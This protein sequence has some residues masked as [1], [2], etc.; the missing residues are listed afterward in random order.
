M[1]YV[2]RVFLIDDDAIFNMVHVKVLEKALFADDCM[3]F[4]DAKEPLQI[5]ENIKDSSW[6]ELP[7]LIFL[8]ISMQGMDGWG[9]LDTLSKVSD[10]K[11]GKCNVV[12]L[13]SSINTEDIDKSKQYPVVLDFISKPLTQ[14]KLQDLKTK[15][16]SFQSVNSS[17]A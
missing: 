3:V 5:I 1:N 7:D 9:F 16:D 6:Q 13:S 2:K 4:D 14:G 10:L 17:L 15:L 8:D 12:M 11:P